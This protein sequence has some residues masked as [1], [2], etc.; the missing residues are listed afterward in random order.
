[1]K[2]ITMVAALALSVGACTADYVQE[3]NAA[4]LFRV[5]DVNL[6]AALRSDVSNVAADS[7]PVTLAVRNKNPNAGVP[8][9]SVQSAVFVERYEIRY[10]RSDG[11]NV[12]GVDVPY[13]ISGNLTTVVD[14]ATSGGVGVTLEVVRAQAKLEPPLRNLRSVSGDFGGSALILTCFAEITVHGRTTAGQAV[15]ADGRLQID[16]A[17]WP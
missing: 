16:F 12:E 7:A 5:A 2:R 17:D 9:P 11:R 1:M 15:Q 10:Y 4:V 8:V 3:N 13:K 6:G 14:V